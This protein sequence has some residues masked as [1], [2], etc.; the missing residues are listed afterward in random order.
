MGEPVP[1]CV[2]WSVRC[3]PLWLIVNSSIFMQP[4]D[5]E[6]PPGPGSIQAPQL[7]EG[8]ACRESPCALHIKGGWDCPLRGAVLE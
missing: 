7:Q 8:E 2:S 1:T 5:H 3:I 6:C 4:A